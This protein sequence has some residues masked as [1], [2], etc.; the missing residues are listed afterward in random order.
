MCLIATLSIVMLITSAGW[1]GSVKAALQAHEFVKE[2]AFVVQHFKK[3]M[4]PKRVH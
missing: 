1:A 3:G 2:L 4:S